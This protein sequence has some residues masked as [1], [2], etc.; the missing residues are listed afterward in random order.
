MT[1]EAVLAA[2][3]EDAGRVANAGRRGGE[4]LA[5]ALVDDVLQRL[6]VARREL[7]DAGE[8]PAALRAVGLQ[9]DALTESLRSLTEAMHADLVARRTLEHELGRERDWSEALVAAVQDGLVVLQGG[10]ATQVNDRLCAMTGFTQE[11]LV[12]GRDG[13]PFWPPEDREAFVALMRD[14]AAGEPTEV[15][16]AIVRRDGSRFPAVVV[17]RAAGDGARLLVT[18]RDDSAAEQASSRRRLELEL[19]AVVATTNRLR[20]LLDAARGVTDEAGLAALLRAIAH[21]ISED[22]GWAVVI[23]LYRPAWDDF[24][25]ATGHGVPRE[26]WAILEGATYEWAAWTPL[27]DE[28]FQRR[29]AYMVPA[30]EAGGPGADFNVPDVAQDGHEAWRADDDLLI[31]FRH[32]H[33]HFLGILSLDAPASGRRPSDA[34]LDVL[35]ALAAHAAL[36]VQH[37][38][39]A[40]ESTRHAA[41]IEQ[42]LHVSS[43]I[44]ATRQIGPMLDVVAHAIADALGFERVVIEAL[45]TD[46]R[47]RPRAVRLPLQDAGARRGRDPV[48]PG[49]L[50]M[51]LDP[52]FA[53][54]GCFLFTREE[55]AE[56]MPPRRRAPQGSQRN[57]R[58][59]RAWD[60]HVV[61]VPL[62]GADDQVVGVVWVDDPVDRLLPG[63]DRLQ[64]LHAF[65]NLATAAMIASDRHLR[66]ERVALGD[67]ATDPGDRSAFLSALERV[68]MRGAETAVVALVEVAGRDDG[69]DPPDLAALAEILRAE[70]RPGDRAFML[71][72]GLFA[73][74]LGGGHRPPGTDALAPR[75]APRARTA[76]GARVHVGTA[77]TGPEG[78]PAAAVLGRA[79]AG[80][81]AARRA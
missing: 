21:T 41:A 73:L 54:E 72:G 40:I 28:R 71:G 7:D 16:T 3:E 67:P 14:G 31:P 68:V 81:L 56:R 1:S 42:L 64:A 37:A 39:T 30:G 36:A 55:A 45:D 65:A 76:G 57:G 32:T 47:L 22:L 33:G 79:S 25:V 4:R 50:A 18:L 61:L 24:V 70:L 78:E 26:G 17:A 44:A 10:V 77:V 19:G 52:G 69:G 46:G 38:Q 13:S 34:E 63:S 27:L 8:E 53:V 29:G 20:G 51:L 48:R 5:E 59:W 23:N 35:V 74:L 62:R 11:E 60:D 58:G 43:Q 75:P 66:L 49:E 2:R 80:L 9:L 12:G 6:V 15:H